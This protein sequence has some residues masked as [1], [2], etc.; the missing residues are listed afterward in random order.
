[1][2]NPK[3]KWTIQN[4]SEYIGKIEA[5]I[6]VSLDYPPHVTDSALKRRAKIE[7][8][9]KNFELLA[10]TFPSKTIMPVVHGRT[11]A[12][13]E[14]SVELLAERSDSLAWIGLG[15]I[16][17]LLQHRFVSKDILKIGPE[18]FISRALKI[19]RSTFPKTKI[20]AFGAGGTRTFP[21][22]FSLGADSADRS[23]GGR[24]RVLGQ[25]FCLSRASG[26]FVGTPHKVP[27]E[28][29]WMSPT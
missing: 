26:W 28:N 13:I 10:G 12:E 21:A 27:H 5:D 11:I 18:I 24:Q 20:H 29:C 19:I 6:F 2:T 7:A 1:M 23:V 25:Y 22:L 14:L 8:S 9:T 15:G 16:V 3:S 4:V 17:P